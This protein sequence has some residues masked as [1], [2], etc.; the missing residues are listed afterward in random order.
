M[1]GVQTCAL[2]ISAGP[3]PRARLGMTATVEASLPI[4]RDAVVVPLSALAKG[5]GGSRVWLV[6]TASATVQP[7]E[8]TLGPVVGEGVH[9]VSGLKPG[10]VVVTAGTQFLVPGKK[11]RLPA[12]SAATAASGAVR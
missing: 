11:V 8:V 6:D 4:A 5:D 12:V 1:T 9:V 2:P 10:D 7:R 3:A